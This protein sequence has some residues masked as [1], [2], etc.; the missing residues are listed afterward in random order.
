VGVRVGVQGYGIP[1]LSL[2]VSAIST[3]GFGHLPAVDGK[4][5][6]VGV[7]NFIFSGRGKFFVQSIGIDVNN[8]VQ[9]KFLF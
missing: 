3:F 7:A 9:L 2:I 5:F 1:F 6:F 4:F 8:T